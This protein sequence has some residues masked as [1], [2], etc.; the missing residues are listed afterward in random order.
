MVHIAD[1][2]KAEV[3][4]LLIVMTKHK[5]SIFLLSASKTKKNLPKYY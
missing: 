4:E 3:G 2:Y 5:F 1:K